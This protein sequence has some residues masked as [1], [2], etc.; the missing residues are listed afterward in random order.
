MAEDGEKESKDEKKVLPPVDKTLKS[1]I[2]NS[3]PKENEK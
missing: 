2:C 1:T 3:I